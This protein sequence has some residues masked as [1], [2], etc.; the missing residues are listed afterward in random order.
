MKYTILWLEYFE[1]MEKYEKMKGYLPK[2]QKCTGDGLMGIEFEVEDTFEAKDI[3]EAK[4]VIRD[5]YYE[6]EVFV[7][8]D[9]KRNKVFTDEDM[10]E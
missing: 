2:K 9:D 6:V 10:E 3:E 4:Q 5:E 8:F 7:V 1:D